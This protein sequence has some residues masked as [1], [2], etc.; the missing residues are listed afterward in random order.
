MLGGTGSINANIYM[1]GNAQNYDYWSSLGNDGWDYESVLPYFKKSEAN[2]HAPFVSYDNGRYHSNSGPMKIDFLGDLR[3]TDQMFIN[4]AA[5]AGIP[6][7]D[8]LNADKNIG[9]SNYQGNVADGRRQSSAKAFLASAK[10]RQN[11]HVIKRALAK[12]IL[13]KHKRA[14]GVKFTYKGKVMRAH[15]REEVILSAGT[16]MSPVILMR[17]GIGPNDELAKH[18]ITPKSN[19]NGV[20]KNL[21]DHVILRLFF[22]FNPTETTTMSPFDSLYNF[23]VNNIGPYVNSRFVGAFVSSKNDPKYADVQFYP[24]YFTSNSSAF[25]S[26]LQYE[27]FKSEIVDELIEINKNHNVAIIGVE[28]MQPKSRGSIELNGTSINKPII[29]PEYYANREDMDTM[30]SE[31]KRQISFTNTK[32]YK[33]N[34]GEFLWLPLKACENYELKSDAYLECYIQQFSFPGYHPVGTSKMGPSSDS[35]AVVDPQL[36]VNGVQGLRVID[37]SV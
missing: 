31:A 30:M 25:R 2:Q 8:N 35:E 28:I 20:G 37:A 19:L 4:A 36:R 11:L 32:A 27:N 6:Y 17:S 12:K 3:E 34:G 14:H 13:I 21:Y 33:A 29:R 10:D 1:R 26:H 18:N 16:V 23:A 15:A 9:Y 5:E 7:V 22:T 24:V